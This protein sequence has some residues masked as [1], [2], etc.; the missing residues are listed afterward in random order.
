[1]NKY[2]I[3]TKLNMFKKDFDALYFW[4]RVATC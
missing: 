3:D 2:N 4:V 1:M